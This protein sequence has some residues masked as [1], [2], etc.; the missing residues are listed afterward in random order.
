[1]TMGVLSWSVMKTQQSVR[2]TDWREWRRL[3]ARHLDDVR[4]T[5]KG[6]TVARVDAENN[7]LMIRGAVPGANGSVV[8]VRKATKKS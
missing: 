1:M 2:S 5:T 4:I 6:L 8:V 3:R 7:I